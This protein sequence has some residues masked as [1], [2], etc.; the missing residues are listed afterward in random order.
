MLRLRTSARPTRKE[1]SARMA[2]AAKPAG[3]SSESR[4]AGA[5]ASFASVPLSASSADRPVKGLSAIASDYVD[6]VYTPEPTDRSTKIVFIQVMRELLDGVPMKPSDSGSGYGYQDG[7]TTGDLY[8]VDFQKGE[9]D[10]Y[11]N[12]DDRGEKKG[13]QG[14][15]LAK[16]PTAATMSDGPDFADW[17]FPKGKS[18]LV[19][20]FR[21][22]AFSAAGEDRG[23]YYA[24]VDWTYTKVKK[25]PGVMEVGASNS[26]D[27]G[28]Q[29][30]SAVDLFCS[31][32]GFVLPVP[33][34]QAG[35][36][37]K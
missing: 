5:G 12:G 22:A 9:K 24:Y 32:R 13:K 35:G 10:P 20:E 15:A 1:R 28:S 8:H 11:Y 17:W 30:R 31:N 2:P 29:F 3:G 4:D 6:F 7:S 36:G 33:S 14:N 25:Q 23:S 34:D 18:T 27:P 37:Q 16:K 26:G 19:W 21:T